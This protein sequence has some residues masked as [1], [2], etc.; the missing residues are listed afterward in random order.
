[1]PDKQNLSRTIRIDL[2]PDVTPAA[3]A[4]GVRRVVVAKP[5]VRFKRAGS[6]REDVSE[7][8]R[9]YNDLLQS[10]YDAALI[11]DLSGRIVYANLRAVE[12]LLYDEVAMKRMSVLDIISGADATLLDNVWQNLA[13]SRFTIIKAFCL[14]KDGTF[15]PCEI[16]VSK[17]WIEEAHL[18]FFVRDITVRRQQEE[19][20]RTEHNAIQNADSGIAVAN[21]N[22]SLE[23]VNP[24]TVRMWGYASAEEL[25]N[26][27]VSR[28]FTDRV[29]TREMIRTVLDDGRTW[30][31]EMEAVRCDGARME[32]Q[33]SAVRNH[34]TDGET[35]GIVFSFADVSDRKRAEVALR[36]ADRQRVML[37]SIGAACHH[38][39]QPATVLLSNIEVMQ[40]LGY[41]GEKMHELAAMSK[42]AAQ[43]L[44]SILRKL[45]AVDKYRTESYLGGEAASEPERSSIV[46]I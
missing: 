35:V 4:G 24:A 15:F 18:C 23:Y 10:V 17:L 21:R 29:K 16:S 22:A 34:N 8:F 37:E 20:L 6:N 1:M 45:N 9:L 42:E 46:E 31:G 27:D 39:S 30:T 11:C 2:I 3:E 36:E 43:S 33:V 12:F 26:A 40:R 5:T 14:R 7:K 32:V 13:D 25:A 38:M 44:G 28:F 19:M 41:Q